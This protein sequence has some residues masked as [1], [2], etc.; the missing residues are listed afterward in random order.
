MKC[1]KC[2][3]GTEGYKCPV[4]GEESQEGGTHDHDD[5]KV[6][7]CPKCSC[8]NKCGE[9]CARNTEPDDDEDDE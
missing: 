1:E 8:C 7:L 5:K 2:S 4:C 9:D 3:C 6:Q